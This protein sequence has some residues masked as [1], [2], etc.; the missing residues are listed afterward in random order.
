MALPI[1]GAPLVA[2]ALLILRRV[3]EGEPTA[4]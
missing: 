2:L 3:P 4:G 1:V